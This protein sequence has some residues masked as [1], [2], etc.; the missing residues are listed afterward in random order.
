MILSMDGLP[1][2]KAAGQS[3]RDAIHG[4]LLFENQASVDEFVS[5]SAPFKHS[6]T[7]KVL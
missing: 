5:A 4:H 7:L 1:R 2:K 6:E 3:F